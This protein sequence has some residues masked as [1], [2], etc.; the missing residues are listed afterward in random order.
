M[1]ILIA[2]VVAFAIGAASR[3]TRVPSLAPQAIVG[4]LLIV[5]MST[6]WIAADR[7]L[8]QKQPVAVVHVSRPKGAGV[9]TNHAVPLQ[10]K[11]G[12]QAAEDVLLEGK[13]H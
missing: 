10:T 2:F 11:T 12:P 1:K 5:A 3:W 4:S 13:R 6:G 7:F 9:P 8:T